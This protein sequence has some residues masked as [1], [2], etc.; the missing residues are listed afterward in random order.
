[1][2]VL[3]HSTHW[4]HHSAACPTCGVKEIAVMK[5]F[6]CEGAEPAVHTH[7]AAGILISDTEVYHRHAVYCQ[8]SW[9]PNAG[10]SNKSG[11]AVHTLHCAEFPAG[12]AYIYKYISLRSR[13]LMLHILTA[14][15]GKSD[16]G[17]WGGWGWGGVVGYSRGRGQGGVFSLSLLFPPVDAGSDGRESGSE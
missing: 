5:S 13:P 7:P 10:A 2:T 4:R 1:M 11:P 8:C 6:R 17:G 12:L 14:P 9:S 16:P 3:H 15:F